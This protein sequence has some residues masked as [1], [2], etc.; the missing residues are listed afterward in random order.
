M[1]SIKDQIA[2]WGLGELRKK[3]S[4][5]SI[6]VPVGSDTTLEGGVSKSFRLRRSR[7]LMR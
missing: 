6:P 3:D 5:K 4:K 1:A 2:H 7:N